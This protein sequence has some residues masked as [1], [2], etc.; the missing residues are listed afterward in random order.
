MIKKRNQSKIY[1]YGTSE[2]YGKGKR[3]FKKE[4]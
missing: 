4:T 3:Y 2:K 1:L